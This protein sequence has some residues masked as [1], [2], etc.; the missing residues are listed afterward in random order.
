LEEIRFMSAASP[1]HGR[2]RVAGDRVR[3]TLRAALCALGTGVVCSA[4]YPADLRVRV[5]DESGMAL[6]DAV[7]YAT[8]TAPHARPATGN[9]VIDQIQR[10]FVPRDT[11]V[12]SGTTIA[13]P[14]SDN[15]HHSVYSFSPARTFTLP[16]Y[17]GKTASPVVFDKPGVVVLGCSIHDSMVAW[18][19]VVDTPYYAHTDAS[20][21]ARLPNLPPGDYVLRAWYEPMAQEA[22]GEMVHVDSAPLAPLTLRLDLTSQGAQAMPG[23]AQ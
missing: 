23:T 15:I 5:E 11:V 22:P 13:F 9:A 3:H 12:Q 21:S 7:V 2:D 17:A 4:A 18:V 14:N 6:R 19:L 1:V 20:G 8:P 10:Q 16:L